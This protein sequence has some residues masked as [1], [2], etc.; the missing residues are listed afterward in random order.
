MKKSEITGVQFVEETTKETYQEFISAI[1]RM[2]EI[3]NRLST[4]LKKIKDVINK[5]L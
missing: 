3:T 2:R 1:G 5:I 4:N